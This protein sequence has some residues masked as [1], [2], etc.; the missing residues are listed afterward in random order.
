MEKEVSTNQKMHQPPQWLPWSNADF[1]QYYF[2]IFV[3]MVPLN[4]VKM[5]TPP[6]TLL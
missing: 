3:F 2:T 5:P 6:C 1:G 4:T